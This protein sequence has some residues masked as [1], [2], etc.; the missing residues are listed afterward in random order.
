MDYDASSI[1]VLKGLE[2]VRKRPAMYIGDIG[3]RGFHHLFYEILDNSIDESIA[4]YADK[5]EVILHRDGFLEV[6][7]NG[8]G[9]PVNEHPQFKKSALELVVTTLHAGGKFDKK[10]YKISGGL[11]GVGI[12]V[13]CALSEYMEVTV[14]REGKVFRQKYSRGKALTPVEIIGETEET[15]TSVKFKPDPEIFTWK[16]FDPEIIKERIREVSFLNKNISITFKNYNK[17]PPE[18]ETFKYEKGLADFV[19][20]LNS[21]NKVISPTMYGNGE[22]DLVKVEFAFAYNDTYHEKLYS[23]VNNI[24]TEEGGTHVSGFKA[25]LTRAI[26]D[27]IKKNS[28]LKD[29]KRV[30]GDD[31]EE[32]LTAVISVLHPEPQ[33]EG[34]TKTKLGNSEVKGIVDSIAF[35]KIKEWLEINKDAAR[36]ITKKIISNMEAREAARRV[37]ENLRRKS[38]FES[39]L[40]PGKLADC[41]T[42]ELENSELFIVEGDS[43]GGSAKQGRD[44]EFQAILPLKGKILNVEK[45]SMEKLLR[46]EEIKNIIFAIGTDI[47]ESFNYSKL[48]YGR[49]IIMTD[50]DVDGSHIRTLLLTLF[51]R[52]FRPLIEKGHIYIARPPLY[53]VSKGKQ[54]YY[55]YS[56]EELNQLLSTIPN[57]NVQRYKGLG[58]M[59]PE[60]LWKTTMDPE[61]RVLKRVSIE[62]AIKA[63]ELF[64]I[65]LGEN[66]EVR[67]R[68]IEEHALE[69]KELDV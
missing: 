8:R 44:R 26:N 50:A 30:S 6:S 46:N 53:K 52:Y 67:R 62:D 24:R 12:S 29:G 63:D 23:Y 55:A 16:E 43:A 1:K 28:L 2:A 65:L 22:N 60:Q 48:R 27:F 39:S 54:V 15:G 69:V 25:A 19:E 57:A 31:V 47:G 37:K 20:F 36:I 5:I 3:K 66:V 59:N 9:I 35:S 21:G 7:D 58:E 68:F 4:G 11:H 40:L 18:E 64:S 61:N 45:A 10:A 13:V 42:H 17:E 38:V 33:F 14:K 41:S 49:I 51:F 34:Q 56:D 32:G